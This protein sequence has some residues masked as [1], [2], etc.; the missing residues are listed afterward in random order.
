MLEEYKRGSDHIIALKEKHQSMQ[1]LLIVE[2][3]QIKDQDVNIANLQEK[4]H[5]LKLQAEE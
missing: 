1:S 3:D 4:L 2:E 5:K